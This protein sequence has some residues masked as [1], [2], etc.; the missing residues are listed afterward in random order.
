MPS[1]DPIATRILVVR[2]RRVLLDADLAGL[3]GV[4]VKR[5][6]EQ[7]RRNLDR[8]PTDFMFRLTSRETAD[9]RSQIATSSWGGRRY[10][11]YAFTEHGAIMAAT[12]LRPARAVE[13]S[14]YVVRAFVQLRDALSAHRDLSKRLDELE[15]R[16]GKKIGVHDRAIGEVLDAIRRLMTPPEAP[17]KRGI[18]FVRDD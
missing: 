13:V 3:Y 8:F 1:V 11:P 7:L 10:A 5:L 9:L 6:N 17:R 15:A 18:G 16:L 14:V 12:V 2:G 4:T